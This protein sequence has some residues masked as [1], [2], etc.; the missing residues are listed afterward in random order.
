MSID[1]VIFISKET[2]TTAMFILVPILGGG[3]LVGLSVGIFQAVTQINEM[4]LTFI[5]KM[6][7]VG[8]IILLLMPWF[9]DILLT[10]TLEVYNQIPLMIE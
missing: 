5:P 6:A 3:L 4:T 1:Y 10:F 9:L 7:V 2:L 8:F